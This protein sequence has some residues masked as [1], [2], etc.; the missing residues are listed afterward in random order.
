MSKTVTITRKIQ[1]NITGEHIK[2]DYKKLYEWNEMVFRA[3]NTAVSHM[4]FQRNMNEFFYLTDKAKILFA[5][6]NKPDE[7]KEEKEKVLTTSQQNS[8]Y[9]VLSSHYKGKMPSDIYSCLNSELYSTFKKES[10][11]YFAGKK[12]LRTYKRNMP[13]SFSAKGLRNIQLSEDGKY[14]SFNLFGISFKTYFGRDLSGN[15]VI[16][17]R[18]LNGEYKLCNSKIQLDGKKIFLL[19]TFQFESEKFQLT[20]DKVMEAELST[21]FPIV[22]TCNG[23]KF[24]VGDKE[25][26]LHRRI[27][28]QEATRRAQIASRFNNSGKGRKRKMKTVDRFH[29]VEK[30]YIQTRQHQYTAKMISHCLNN[31]CGILKLR[32]AFDQP[33]PEGLS[34]KELSDWGKENTLLL[35]NWSYHGLIDKIKYKCNKTGIELIV[36]KENKENNPEKVL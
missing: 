28:I 31:K 4:Y 25:E 27:A 15:R 17:E 6:I 34:R 18:S 24:Y 30:N 16:F 20:E 1:L 7:K 29:N 13:M 23:K 9:Q 32:N 14:Y 12:S 3:A 33:E 21:E 35:R 26:Y 11:D 36:E 19:A 5:D 10:V 22:L 2:E 8:T